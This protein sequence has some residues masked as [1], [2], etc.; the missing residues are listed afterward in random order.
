MKAKALHI[1]ATEAELAK[2][3]RAAQAEGMQLSDWVR[4]ALASRMDGGN[5]LADAKRRIRAAAAILEARPLP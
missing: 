4:S 3:H 5:E 1:R 2:W